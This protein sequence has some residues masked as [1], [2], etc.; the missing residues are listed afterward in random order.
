MSFSLAAW[1]L[2]TMIV[3]IKSDSKIQE[4]HNKLGQLKNLSRV[5]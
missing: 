3:V 4:L 5:L 2:E 1:G